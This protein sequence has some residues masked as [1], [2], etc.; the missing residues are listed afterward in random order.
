MSKQIRL[1]IPTA[2]ELS[3][4][5]KI[6]ITTAKELS[7]LV[8]GARCGYLITAMTGEI[9]KIPEITL[10]PRSELKTICGLLNCRFTSV[11]QRRTLGL[12]I[13]L[14]EE[15]ALDD[16]EVNQKITTL[17][18]FDPPYTLHGDVIVLPMCYFI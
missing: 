10:S 3:V 17:L 7:E 13:W 16:R 18:D 4:I 9:K 6:S 14:D 1:T 15:G 2:E 5:S 12:D 8:L 11:I